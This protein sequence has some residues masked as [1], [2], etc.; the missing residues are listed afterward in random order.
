[1]QTYVLEW[2]EGRS[3]KTKFHASFDIDHLRKSMIRRFDWT[4][5]VQVTVYSR[6]HGTYIGRLES[7]MD[8][9]V[10]TIPASE[11]T[12]SRSRNVDARTG[13]LVR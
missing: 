8:G 7:T 10:W 3:T 12:P 9:F 4:K 11:N 1:M 2:K 6:G 13:R 5:T